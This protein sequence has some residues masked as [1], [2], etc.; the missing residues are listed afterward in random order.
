MPE[1]IQTRAIAEIILY[2]SK[3]MNLGR[4]SLKET[5]D[6]LFS[7]IEEQGLDVISRYPGKHPGD[8]ALPR[9][10]E[11]AGAINRMRTLVINK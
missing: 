10:M 2:L 4:A 1:C 6:Q 3:N 11:V 7:R 5:L 8:L 9:K